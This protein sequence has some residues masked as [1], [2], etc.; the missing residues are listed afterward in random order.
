VAPQPAQ[1]QQAKATTVRLVLVPHRVRQAAA[2]VHLR[3]VLP[4]VRL[5][6]VTVAQVRP[7][8]IPVRLSRMP[9]A[10][11]V[12]LTLPVQRARVVRV[13][14]VQAVKPRDLS[15][16]WPEQQT[17]AAVAVVPMALARRVPAAP[18]W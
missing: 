4:V 5:P 7:I 15:L 3:R 14:A 13:A 18:A 2:V 17:P 8:P 11:V 10:V 9:V 12:V 1:V 6:P 16:P